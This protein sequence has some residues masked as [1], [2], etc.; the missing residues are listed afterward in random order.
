[1]HITNWYQNL[2]TGSKKMVSSDLNNFGSKDHLNLL[3]NNKINEY[4]FLL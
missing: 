1:M 3:N 2:E 4:I